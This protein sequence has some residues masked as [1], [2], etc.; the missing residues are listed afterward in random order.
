MIPAMVF[1]QV[2]DADRADD[3]WYVL[4]IGD[5]IELGSSATAYTTST[6]VTGSDHHG[7]YLRSSSALSGT[8]DFDVTA[9]YSINKNSGFAACQE[10]VTF[11]TVDVLGNKPVKLN[12]IAHISFIR[13]KFVSSGSNTSDL[14]ID[15]FLIRDTKVK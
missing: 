10:P 7:L 13:F 2:T 1:G 15:A 6:R 4:P 12:G 8:V 11:A 5:Q 9:E 14:K 3:E